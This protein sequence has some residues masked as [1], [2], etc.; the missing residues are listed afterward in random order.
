MPHVE[1]VT[2]D[3]LLSDR[4]AQARTELEEIRERLRTREITA[5]VVVV[6]DSNPATAILEFVS[7]EKPDL[8]AMGTHGRK[9][10][11]RMVLGSVADKVVRS[12][13]TP[14][15]LVRPPWEE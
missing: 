10:M 8:V 15:L 9:G 11:A 12:A 3:R 2:Y 6:E 4:V 7:S 1:Y 13:T 14:V 5:D